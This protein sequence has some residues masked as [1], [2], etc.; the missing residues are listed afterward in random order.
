MIS[1]THRLSS[2]VAISAISGLMFSASLRTGTTME[3]ATAAMSER[4]KSTLTV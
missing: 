3:T 4:G 2:A 1:Y